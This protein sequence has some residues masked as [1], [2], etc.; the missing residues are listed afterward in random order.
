MDVFKFLIH[1]LYSTYKRD[2]VIAMM[3]LNTFRGPAFKELQGAL[4]QLQDSSGGSQLSKNLC[5]GRSIYKMEDGVSIGS[6]LSYT[7]FISEGNSHPSP[8]S[9]IREDGWS[10]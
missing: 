1:I 2:V 7:P 3:L 9:A 4:R 6:S 8:V 5:N 10:Q